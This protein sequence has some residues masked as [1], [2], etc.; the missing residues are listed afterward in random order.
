M[1][2]KYLVLFYSYLNSSF[3]VKPQSKL[4]GFFILKINFKEWYVLLN[5]LC[6]YLERPELYKQ[7][8]IN[9]GMMSIFQS[10]Y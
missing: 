9:F 6:M 7:S 4:C 8:E 10:N 2:K 5:K 1:L 3:E